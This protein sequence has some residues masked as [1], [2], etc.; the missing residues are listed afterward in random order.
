MQQEIVGFKILI[1]SPNLQN[2]TCA[3]P[4]CNING[5][6]EIQACFALFMQTF[7]PLEQVQ[8]EDETLNLH[9]FGSSA[10]AFQSMPR[11]D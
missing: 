9:L 4:H 5:G 6:R 2:N 8:G 11:Y 10:L 3:A 7:P 1:F